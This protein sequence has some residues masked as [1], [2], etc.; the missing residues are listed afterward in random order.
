MG[1]CVYIIRSLKNNDLY[2]GS[3]ED[4]DNRIKLHNHG[5]VKSTKAYKPWKLLEIRECNNRSEAVK[6]ER[7]LKTGQ[8][9][10]MLRRRYGV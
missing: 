5:R 6:L 3:T 9:K 10:E 2:V 7:F 8:Q 1:F 4:F